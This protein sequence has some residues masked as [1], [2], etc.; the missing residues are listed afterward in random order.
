[1]DSEEI[2]TTAIVRYGAQQKLAELRAFLD[3]LI[4]HRIDSVL[5]IGSW[6]GGTLWA[7]AQIASEVVSIDVDWRSEALDPPPAPVQRIL[8]NSHDE[9]TKAKLQGRS[10]D[11]VFIDGDHTYEGVKRD[12]EMYAPLGR[13]VAIHDIVPHVTSSGIH[14]EPFWAEL[15]HRARTIEFISIPPCPFSHQST[16]DAGIGVVL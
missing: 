5:E 12:Y 10:F 4:P 15:T 1:M 2:A 16:Y 14:V 7:W 8:G 6:T 13:L 9:A 3:F 11:L